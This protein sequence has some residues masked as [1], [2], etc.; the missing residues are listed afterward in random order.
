MVAK[1]I[2]RYVK[3]TLNLKLL[4][5]N[6]KNCC[7]GRIVGY[8]E[9][10]KS[11]DL[12]MYFYMK[13]LLFHGVP[14]CKVA[15]LQNLMEQIHMRD[16]EQMKLYVDNVSTINLAKHLVLIGKS[17]HIETKYHFL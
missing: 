16:K 15:W 17:K 11:G 9:N 14:A 1:R 4:F 3:V 2:L 6:N 10:D 7:E 5:S 13:T 8:L 12:A